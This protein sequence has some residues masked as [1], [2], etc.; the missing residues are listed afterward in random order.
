MGGLSPTRESAL[1]V[2]RI[3]AEEVSRHPRQTNPV[4]VSLHYRKFGLKHSMALGSLARRLSVR[5]F[6]SW[7][8]FF[9]FQSQTL[10]VRFD[11][12]LDDGEWV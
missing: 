12:L 6:F 4:C 10:F 11:P 3:V 5:V 7:V 2:L 8:A 1:E 9:F